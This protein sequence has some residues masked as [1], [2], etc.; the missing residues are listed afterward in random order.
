MI[1]RRLFFISVILAVVIVSAPLYWPGAVLKVTPESLMSLIS[2]GEV[3]AILDVR[4][5]FEFE[6]E[7]IPHAIHAPLTTLLFAHDDLA[8]SRQNHVIVYCGTGLRAR[9]ASAYL[10]LVGFKSVYMLE[11]QLRDWKRSGYSV[12]VS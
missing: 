8:V 4:T 12:V 5:N 2:D 7:H 9:F 10:K 11:G 1:Q 6:S 3:P